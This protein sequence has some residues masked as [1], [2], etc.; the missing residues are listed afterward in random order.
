MD[1]ISETVLP[2]AY[3]EEQTTRDR[4]L[5]DLGIQIDKLKEIGLWRV[6]DFDSGKTFPLEL[7]N[8][9]ED[10]LKAK[11]HPVILD[12]GAGHGAVSQELAGK[13][14]Q[15][16]AIAL[17]LYPTK[18][19]KSNILSVKANLNEGLPVQK[20]VAD[21]SLGLYISRYL[22]DPLKLVNEMTRATKQGGFVV[23]NGVNRFFLNMSIEQGRL[24][25]VSFFSDY[26]ETDRTKLQIFANNLSPKT[27][28]WVI[29]QVFDPDYQIPYALQKQYSV[30][31]SDFVSGD[32]L[33]LKENV[34]NV[35]QFVYQKSSQ[36][37]IT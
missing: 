31:I 18:A 15:L 6:D 19:Q 12:V 34:M 9:V 16:K 7:A 37:S 27:E 30:V 8:G 24:D 21:L 28:D 23:L 13:I 20:G 35:V 17:D 26:L 4:G 1:K 36:S 11:D 29:L 5:K 33:R 3:F 2:E 22:E 25:R 10:Y 32:P 14:P